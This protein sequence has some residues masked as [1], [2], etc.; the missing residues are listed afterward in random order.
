MLDFAKSDLSIVLTDV[1]VSLIEKLGILVKLV[2][3]Q[4]LPQ[5]LFELSL[6][7]M[8]G[9]PTFKSNGAHD[10]VY[11]V[12]NPLDQHGGLAMFF[13]EEFGQGCLAAIDVFFS[14]RLAFGF[15]HFLG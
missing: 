1:G 2:L 3:E 15:H 9:L 14:G 12:N 8:S 10:L 5:C 4:R 7:G 6:A 11:V 13:L